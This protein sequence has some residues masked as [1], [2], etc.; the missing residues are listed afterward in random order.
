MRRTYLGGFPSLSRTGSPGWQ[1]GWRWGDAF[2][3]VTISLGLPGQGTW[4][5][6]AW[7]WSCQRDGNWDEVDGLLMQVSRTVDIPSRRTVPD[8][9]SLFTTAGTKWGRIELQLPQ[10]EGAGE[11]RR[12][13]WTSRSCAGLKPQRSM[14]PRRLRQELQA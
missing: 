8:G 9:V 12:P 10:W 1:S 4:R 14:R 7:P 6:F 13:T 5:V 11:R 3:V 2:I